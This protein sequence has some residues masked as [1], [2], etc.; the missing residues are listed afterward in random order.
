MKKWII[1]TLLCL[2]AFTVRANDTTVN[3]RFNVHFQTTYIYQHKPEFD[4]PYSGPNSLKRFKENQNSLTATLFVGVRLWK[5]ADIYINPEVAGGSGLSGA[6]GLGASTNGETFRVGDAAPALYLARGYFQ[7]TFRLGKENDTLDDL[8]NQVKEVQPKRYLK[9][10]IGKYA[11]SDFFDGN[12]FA[13]SPRTQFMNWCLMSNGAWDFAANLRGYTYGFTTILQWDKMTYKLGIATEPKVANGPDLNMDISKARGINLEA[14]RQITLNKREGNIRLLVYNNNANMG[15]YTDALHTYDPS[16]KPNITLT[17]KYGRTKTGI[18]LNADQQLTDVLGVFAR[19]GWNDGKS[20]T[21]A[22]TEVDRT[23]TLG[24]SI[25][26]DKW[27]R[28]D[29]NIGFA[30]V[31]NGL[32]KPHRD[33]LAAGGLGFQ[34]G[35]GRLNYA[36]ESAAELYYSFKPTY[37]GIWLTGDYQFILNPGYN[38]DRGPVNVFSLRLHVEL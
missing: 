10:C 8:Q 17:E 31:V 19:L 15:I 7:Q 33:Y 1:Y 20:E 21:W 25:K 5:G 24:L 36:N 4:A 22:F 18:G 14:D 11:L 27:K 35:D 28:G 38:A 13:G 9:F 30:V 29:D 23:A 2:A 3:Q 12:S 37:L 32:S 26:G 6:F 34:L 16:G